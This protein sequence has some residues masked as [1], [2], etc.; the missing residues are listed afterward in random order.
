MY[1][2][3]YKGALIYGLTNGASVFWALCIG[4]L[5]VGALYMGR[6]EVERRETGQIAE[7]REISFKRNPKAF[8]K[9]MLGRDSGVSIAVSFS[10]KSCI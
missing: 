1:R 9:V 4:A 7:E 8:S 2:A 10:L 5:Y 6:R 3:L